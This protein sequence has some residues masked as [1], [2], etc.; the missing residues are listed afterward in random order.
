LTVN[1]I[2]RDE[3]C[4]CIGA[5][6]ILRKLDR[7]KRSAC[8]RQVLGVYLVWRGAAPGLRVYVDFTFTLLNREH[9]S[10]N[11]GFS[12]K[13]VKFTY[14]APAQGNRNYI[15][16]SDLYSRNFAD[17]NGEFQLE[18]SMTNV[19]T[20]FTSEVSTPAPF[21]LLY[22]LYAQVFYKPLSACVNDAWWAGG[23]GL[24][25]ASHSQWW[26]VVFSFVPD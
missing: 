6:H 13:R 3:C 14:E 18:L 16:V 21:P 19:R 10:V 22:A 11:E 24:P 20:V 8:D 9:F 7:Q 1:E 2:V 15:S 12:G 17:P 26:D 5:P 23:G 25:E 4:I